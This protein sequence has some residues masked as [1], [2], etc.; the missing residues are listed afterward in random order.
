MD[1]PFPPA[2]MPDIQAF[3]RDVHP[4]LP[5]GRTAYPEVFYSPSFYP[6]QRMKETQRMIEIASSVCPRVVMEIGADKG[7]GLYHWCQIPTVDYVIGCEVRGTPYAEEFERGFPDRQFLWLPQSSYAPGTF[8]LVRSWLGPKTI[9]C[10]FIDGEKTQ[11]MTDFRTYLPLM[12]RGG[13]VFLHDVTE[14][15]MGD[16]FHELANR[17]RSDLIVNREESEAAVER[18]RLKVP[19]GSPYE[20]WLRHWHGRSCGVGVLYMDR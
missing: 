19:V 3:F 12:R 7:G 11:F 2:M 16:V 8:S 4:H 5:P 1:D 10:L 17:Y 18:G 20:G 15:P 6:L 13:V 14:S 9:D